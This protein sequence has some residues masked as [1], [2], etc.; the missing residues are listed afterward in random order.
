MKRNRRTKKSVSTRNILPDILKLTRIFVVVSL[1]YISSGFIYDGVLPFFGGYS[2]Y[3]CKENYSDYGYK[4]GELLVF[5]D[6]LVADNTSS[7]VKDIYSKENFETSS[8]KIVI[9]NINIPQRI[10]NIYNNTLNILK[11]RN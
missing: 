10:E 11:H 2:F 6:S 8:I 1:L 3:V 7:L 9:G 5:K 4:E